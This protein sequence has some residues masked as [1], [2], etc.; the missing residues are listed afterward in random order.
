MEIWKAVAPADIARA[1]LIDEAL[2]GSRRRARRVASVAEAGGLSVVALQGEIEGFCCLD[3]DFFFEKPFASLLV[4]S[5]GA[6]RSGLGEALLAH[7]AGAQ[8][9][10]WTSTNRSNHAMRRLLEKARWTYCGA[11]CG[12]DEDDPEL[13]FKTAR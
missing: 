9:E 6:R 7:A 10:V 5:P 4:I 3:H 8:R 2:V 13:F 1:T 12:L 11:L